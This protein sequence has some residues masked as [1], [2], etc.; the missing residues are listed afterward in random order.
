VLGLGARGSRSGREE[1][2]GEG[3]G[4]GTEGTVRWCAGTGPG[5][6]QQSSPEMETADPAGRPATGSTTLLSTG[7]T[8]PTLSVSV[9]VSVFLSVCLCLS[10][11]LSLSL[12]S[13]PSLSLPP[14]PEPPA[15]C[16]RGS[17]RQ[18]IA[19][20][21]PISQHA[22]GPRARDTLM[23]RCTVLPI[24]FSHPPLRLA[25]HHTLPVVACSRS[26]R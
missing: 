4:E 17:P 5:P 9:S 15:Q 13:S 19:W 1:D 21:G 8:R 24:R 12:T 10:V 18:W 3:T 11:S 20:V 16:A 2:R 22:V 25:S 7:P 23:T 14:S 26:R 6:A